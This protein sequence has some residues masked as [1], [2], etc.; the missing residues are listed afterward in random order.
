MQSEEKSEPESL[1][2][3]AQFIQTVNWALDHDIEFYRLGGRDDPL[4]WVLTI[5][6]SRPWLKEEVKALRA[7]LKEWTSINDCKYQRS[8]WGGHSFK[9]L[10]LLKGLGPKKDINPYEVT[11]DLRWAGRSRF[12]RP[13]KRACRSSHRDGPERPLPSVD[14][15]LAF[16]GGEGLEEDKP[17]ATSSDGRIPG[18]LPDPE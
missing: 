15:L 13:L 17:Y 16:T 7:Q 3:A 11:G 8:E 2:W 6:L 1:A 4:Q 10:I 18:F 14:H 9:A 12:G 5:S